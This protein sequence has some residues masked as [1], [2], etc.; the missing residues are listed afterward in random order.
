MP[1]A[2]RELA[3]ERT[4]DALQDN[5][6]DATGKRRGSA[7]LSPTLD[8]SHS[9]PRKQAKLEDKG[10]AST[11]AAAAD[12]GGGANGG[13]MSSVRGLRLCTEHIKTNEGFGLTRTSTQDVLVLPSPGSDAAGALEKRA[14]PPAKR[15]P[16]RPPFTS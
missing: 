2:R 3:Q 11:S 7:A 15:N 12:A 10:E 6:Q 16:D 8:W 9:G 5:V 14:A 4:D 1:P 13:G